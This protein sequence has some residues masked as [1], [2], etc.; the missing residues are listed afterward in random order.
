MSLDYACVTHFKLAHFVYFV[1]HKIF[2]PIGRRYNST[3]CVMTA[4]WCLHM[5][6]QQKTVHHSLILWKVSIN[7]K[8]NYKTV[9][10][11]HQ[12]HAIL[13]EF[14]V[15]KE[16]VYSLLSSINQELFEMH[17]C[18]QHSYNEKYVSFPLHKESHHVQSPN[19]HFLL[20]AKMNRT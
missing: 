8:G 14:T 16:L 6:Q 2:Y 5:G 10:K 19:Q 12:P 17:L 11:Q 4:L 18:N 7:D 20:S 15:M 1:L 3:F 9:M 13:L